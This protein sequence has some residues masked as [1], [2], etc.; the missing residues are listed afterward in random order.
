MTAI[1]CLVVVYSVE[2]SFNLMSSGQRSVWLAGVLQW[3]RSD[4]SVRRLS[5]EHRQLLCLRRIY[6]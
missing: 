6:L 4:L 3:N 5:T 2:E 1:L